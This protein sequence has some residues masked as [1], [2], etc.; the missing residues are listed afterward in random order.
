MKVKEIIEDNDGSATMIIDLTKEELRQ[1]VEYA[2]LN[3]L[4]EVIENDNSKEYHSP[5]SMR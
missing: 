5:H 2:V 1:L 4:E 3:I